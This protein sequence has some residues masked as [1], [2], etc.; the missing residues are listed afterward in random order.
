MKRNKNIQFNDLI[1]SYL[2]GE[3]AGEDLQHFFELLEKDEEFASFY[4]KYAI[5]WTEKNQL[6]V[7]TE[8]A[9]NKI[10]RRIES[11][12]K[13]KNNFVLKKYSKWA[14]AAA[15]III[16]VL[17]IVLTHQAKIGPINNS[18]TELTAEYS[19]MEKYL[20]DGTLVTLNT[21]ACL[22]YPQDFEQDSIR[23][24]K[25]SGE[26]FFEVTSNPEKAFVIETEYAFIRVLGTK[27]NVKTSGDN[28]VLSVNVSEGKVM[29]YDKSQQ[30]SVIINAGES[31]LYDPNE[32]R[33]Q[34]FEADVNDL[35]WKTGI[36]SFD[37]QNLD[38]VIVAIENY[39]NYR[40]QLSDSSLNLLQITATFNNE[41]IEVVLQVIALTLDIQYNID[42][43]SVTM[44]APKNE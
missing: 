17:T 34:K 15:I 9:W 44:F 14:I 6:N 8:E 4:D 20:S 30:T 32:K 25:L 39:Y 18:L 36:L 12:K 31:C 7:D 16:G 42:S 35:S 11:I 40:I 10:K 29:V 41:P 3:L 1:A 2:S 26:A 21:Q 5:I 22:S 28:N 33:I 27:F 23:K 37:K 13:P 19:G 24:V 38:E 43:T